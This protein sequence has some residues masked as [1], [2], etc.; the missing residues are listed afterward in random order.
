MTN[1]ARMLVR[2]LIMDIVSVS[3]WGDEVLF[4]YLTI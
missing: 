3:L 2:E 1:P 4:D